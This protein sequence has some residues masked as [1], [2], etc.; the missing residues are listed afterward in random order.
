MS[1]DGGVSPTSLDG[2]VSPTSSTNTPL[3]QQGLT[4]IQSPMKLIPIEVIKQLLNIDDFDDEFLIKPLK[5][6]DGAGHDH[7]YYA[8]VGPEDDKYERIIKIQHITEHQNLLSLQLIAK[9]IKI[10]REL[11][12]IAEDKQEYFIGG[13]E[14]KL[15]DENE[16][17]P[18]YTLGYTY[19]KLPYIK[20]VDFHKF[21]SR[22]P[23]LKQIYKILMKTADAL[24]A[25]LNINIAHADIHVGN[26]LILEPIDPDDPKIHLIDFDQSGDPMHYVDFTKMNRLSYNIIGESLPGYIRGYFP[27]CIDILTQHRSPLLE[28]FKILKPDMVHT[29][30]QGKLFYSKCIEFFKDAIND[31]TRTS[32]SLGIKGGRQKTKRR[33]TKRRLTKRRLTKRRLTSLLRPHHR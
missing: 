27:M 3:N 8:S 31:T 14:G 22:Q 10:Y 33:L 16:G 28:T 26:I 29:V 7:V 1:S 5:G 12:S 32:N 18:D 21:L 9:E 24:L 11:K 15:I 20:S 25:L 30:D 2:G 4:P 23:T 13:V 17:F 19:L 6:V